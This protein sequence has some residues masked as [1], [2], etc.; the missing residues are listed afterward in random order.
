MK[1]LKG[2]IAVVTGA[3]SGMGRCMTLQLLE[4]GAIVI[5]TDKN[6]ETLKETESMAPNGE[7]H[8]FT[9]DASKEDQINAFAKKVIKQFGY[10]DILINNAGFALGKIALKDVKMDDFKLLMDVNV[11]GVINHTKAFI[12]VL[13]E[14]PEAS[15]VNISS[16]FGIT[17]LSEQVPYCTTKFAVRGFS[18]SLRMEMIGTN[19]VVTCVHPG[20]IK[21]NIAK[22]SI[23][24]GQEDLLEK[25]EKNLLRIPAEEAAKDIIN[26]IQKKQE[27]LL[28]G[29]EVDIADRIVRSFPVKYSNIIKTVYDKMLN[30]KLKS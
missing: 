23:N 18:E 9:V 10:I 29:I 22:N 1:N 30:A 19:V 24:Y 26:S 17:G 21:T 14:R 6:S 4:K 20:G 2:K 5:A 25:F 28:I 11:W 3:G 7:I 16:L 13:L 8:I 12:D 15:I 27:R